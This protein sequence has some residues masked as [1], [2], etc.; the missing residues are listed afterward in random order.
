M[1]TKVTFLEPLKFVF[2]DDIVC[3]KPLEKVENII[4]TDHRGILKPQENSDA[5]ELGDKCVAEI[6]KNII[7]DFERTPEYCKKM[8]EENPDLMVHVSTHFKIDGIIYVT[9]YASVKTG[10][11]LPAFQEA[12]FAFCPE[13]NPEDMTVITL[14]KVGDMLGGKE[15]TQVYDTIMLRKDDDEIYLMWTAATDRYYRLYC[16]YNIKEHPVGPIMVNRF[17]VGNV[18]NDFSMSGITN[19]L[20]LN[21]IAMHGTFNDIGIMQKISTRVE[22]G[23]TYYYTGAY[24]GYFTCIIKSKDFITWEYVSQP[25][26]PCDS[27]WENATYVLGDKIFYFVRQEKSHEGFLTVYHIDTNTWEKPLLISDTQSRSDFVY[28]KDNL[29]LFHAPIDR[30]GFGIVKIDTENIENSKP[31]LVARMGESMFYSFIRIYGNEAYISY[32][33]DRKHIRLSKFNFDKFLKNY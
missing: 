31:V 9:Y 12:R 2:T 4:I 10:E 14:Q 13:E 24:S 23:E 33:V 30:D 22:N 20:H 29:Y 7:A 18:V 17:K 27:L 26:F 19:A 15:I 8:G 6:K 11:E 25:D 16:V 3:E 5:L 21:G 32:T 1:P 28:Y